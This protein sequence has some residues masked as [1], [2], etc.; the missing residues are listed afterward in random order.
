V[1]LELKVT[2]PEGIPEDKE[3]VVRENSNTLGFDSSD[4]DEE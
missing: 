2:V 3:R 4:F 1:K